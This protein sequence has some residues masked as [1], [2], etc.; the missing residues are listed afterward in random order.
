[1]I[2]VTFRKIIAHQRT[3]YGGCRVFYIIE[4]VTINYNGNWSVKFV[5]KDKTL[6]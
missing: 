2:N 3:L 6:N 4:L 1:M 5:F